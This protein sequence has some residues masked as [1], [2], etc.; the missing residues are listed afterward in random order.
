MAETRLGRRAHIVVGAI[1]AACAACSGSDDQSNP[2]SDAATDAAGD[3]GGGDVAT[4]SVGDGAGDVSDTKPG[5]SVATDAPPGDAADAK[6]DSPP[7]DTG[8]SDATIDGA[9]SCDIPAGGGTC[10]GVSFEC[11]ETAD[12]SGTGEICCLQ[13]GP[14]GITGSA[15]RTSCKS[16]D[17][18]LC[19][20]AA[21]CGLGTPCTT[22]TCAGDVLG[23][24]GGTAPSGC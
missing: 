18:Q 2:L 16:G 13:L 4:D 11:D 7:A 6:S 1:V 24:C 20:S 9:L 3:G 12:C 15:C 8:A 21:E 19:R 22:F 5:D 17:P 23:L 10:N 14:P